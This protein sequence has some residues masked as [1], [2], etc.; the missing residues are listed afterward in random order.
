MTD[1]MRRETACWDD[2]IPAPE[3][4][5]E[6]YVADMTRLDMNNKAVEHPIFDELFKPVAKAY[7]YLGDPRSLSE[8]QVHAIFDT[9]SKP[10]VKHT[11]TAY[12]IAELKAEKNYYDTVNDPFEGVL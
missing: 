12:E 8:Q 6:Q 9:V 11:M 1:T 10:K 5:S 4:M 7:G 3:M 2:A